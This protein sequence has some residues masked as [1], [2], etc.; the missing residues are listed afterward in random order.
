MSRTNSAKKNALSQNV[1][2]VS[3]ICA[4]VMGCAAAPAFAQ[5]ALTSFTV[6]CGGQVLTGGTL[7]LTSTIGQPDA[8]VFSGGTIL[9]RGGFLVPST[10]PAD[11]NASGAVS[12]QDIFDFLAAYFEGDVRADFNASGAI[13]VQDIFD[14]LAAYFAGC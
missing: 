7:R 12:V 11:F 9:L 6:D 8:G 4:A 2:R 14:Y 1:V 13:S 5:P 10:C 3:A